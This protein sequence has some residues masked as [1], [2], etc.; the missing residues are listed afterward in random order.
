MASDK[1]LND[2]LFIDIETVSCFETYD[3]LDEK[4]QPLWDR[5]A[6]FIDR[7]GNSKNLYSERAGIF[8]E[9]GK[10]VTISMGVFFQEKEA[11]C[12]R[13]KSL[14]GDDEA[15]I[16]REFNTLIQKKSDS[17]K[18][19]FCAHNGKEFDYPY[20][21]RRMLINY[22]EL[23]E[24]LKQCS[25]K[26]WEVRHL[27]TLD[28]W[29]FGDRKNYTS[30]ALMA[31]ILGIETSKDDIDGSMVNQVYYKEKNLE[32]IARYCEKDVLVT[33]QLFLRLTGRPVLKKENIYFI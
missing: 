16:L 21:C 13:V 5:K 1:N 17:G 32:R 31:A 18:L 2:L 28:M 24:A 11:L 20:L 30:L 27:D 23:P 7:E 8:A 14:F 12:F 4:L 19:I 26:P 22:I 15:S 25:N 29:K 3:R 9:F 6:F 33:A 10:I